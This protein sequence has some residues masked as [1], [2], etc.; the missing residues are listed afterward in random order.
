MGVLFKLRATDFAMRLSLNSIHPSVNNFLPLPPYFFLFF[1]TEAS[2]EQVN[3]KTNG[4]LK[5]KKYSSYRSK[6]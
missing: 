2:T 1:L 5:F 6:T 3:A 4:N